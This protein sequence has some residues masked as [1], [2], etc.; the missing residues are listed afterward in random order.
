M[1]TKISNKSLLI[2]SI[3]LVVIIGLVGVAKADVSFKEMLAEKIS[4]ILGDKLSESLGLNE[5]VLGGGTRFENGLS[6]DST[7]PNA[8]EIRGT[9]LT[10]TSGNAETQT[11]MATSTASL[12]ELGG[13]SIYDRLRFGD[14]PDTDSNSITYKWVMKDFTAATSTLF[15]IKLEESDGSNPGARIYLDDIA[16]KLTGLATTTIQMFV[17]TSTSQYV[18]NDSLSAVTNI[19][20]SNF[21]SLMDDVLI[22]DTGVFD[23]TGTVLWAQTDAAGAYAGCD[24]GFGTDFRN[25]PIIPGTYIVGNATSTNEASQSVEEIFTSGDLFDGTVYI[26][27]KVVK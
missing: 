23:A 11:D 27:Y 10:I 26:R 4:L 3:A 14:D 17:G 1:N 24:V 7:E 21:C 25:I 18:N 12:S 8:G 6:T 13:I 2:I 22:T 15:A 5:I 16:L 9:T 19:A 20:A